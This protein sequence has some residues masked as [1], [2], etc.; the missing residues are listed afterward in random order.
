MIGIFDKTEEEQRKME[1]DVIKCND[2]LTM[3]SYAKIVKKGK[4]IKDIENEFLALENNDFVYYWGC[5]MPD[6][7]IYRCINLLH[8]KKA[9]EC[10]IDSLVEKYLLADDQTLMNKDPKCL[11]K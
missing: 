8:Y 2:P 6:A 1:P 4:D 5:D 3:Y 11:K 7:D 9:K 10:F